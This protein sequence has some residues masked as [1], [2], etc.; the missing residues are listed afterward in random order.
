MGAQYAPS[1]QP[2]FESEQNAV[3]YPS[4]NCGVLVMQKSLRQPLSCAQASPLSLAPGF[5]GPAAHVPEYR[6][7]CF[8]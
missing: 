4:G 3:Q 5:G 1:G 6:S 2:C 7:H 8:E